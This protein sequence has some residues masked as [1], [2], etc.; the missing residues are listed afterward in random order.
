MPRTLL[1]IGGGESA[2]MSP[3]A[4]RETRYELTVFGENVLRKTADFVRQN[5][6]DQWLGGVHLQG[7][8]NVW[9][10]DEQTKMIE[11]ML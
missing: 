4:V 8:E 7:R 3:K 9:R 11:R 5:G 1:K 6:I 2:D 10:W